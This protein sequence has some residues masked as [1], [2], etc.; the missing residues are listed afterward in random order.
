[1]NPPQ[2]QAGFTLLEVLIALAIVSIALA[3]SIRALGVSAGG[4]HAMQ[5][6]SLALQA[7][8]NNLAELRLQ[9]A[10]PVVGRTTVPCPQG[11][12]ALECE[13]QVQ[14]TVNGNFRQVTVRARLE[15]GPVLAQLSGL[16]S[17]LP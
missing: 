12:L 6:R 8:E 7:A 16:L 5:Q 11:P 15:Q 1:M 2:T 9:R 10:F 17:L 3:A 13:Q 4:A 14:S